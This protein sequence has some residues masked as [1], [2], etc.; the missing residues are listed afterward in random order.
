MNT[1]ALTLLSTCTNLESLRFDCTIPSLR[2]PLRLAKHFYQDGHYFLEALGAAK[3]DKRAAVDVLE[4]SDAIYPGMF[5][6]GEEFEK[7][8]EQFRAELRRLLG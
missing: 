2:W 1:A 7:L 5:Y 6:E 4:L 3:G 8:M